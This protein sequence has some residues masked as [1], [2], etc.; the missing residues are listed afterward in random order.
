MIDRAWQTWTRG[1]RVVLVLSTRPGRISDVL[2]EFPDDHTILHGF[3]EHESIDLTEGTL[4]SLRE[5]QDF[6]WE[7]RENWKRVL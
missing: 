4:V 6:P 5:N 2:T 7:T 3:S 1:D